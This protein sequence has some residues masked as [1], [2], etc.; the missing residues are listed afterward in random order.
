MPIHSMAKYALFTLTALAAL[1]LTALAPTTALAALETSK[2]LGHT[3][4]SIH[5]RLKV[6]V[7]IATGNA[8]YSETDFRVKTPGLPIVFTRTWNSQGSI[9]QDLGDGWIHSYG[10]YVDSYGTYGLKVIQ[11]DGRTHFYD[12]VDSNDGDS[13]CDGDGS[14]VPE[15]VAHDGPAAYMT[16]TEDVDEYFLTFEHGQ[17]VYAFD[18]DAD[19]RLW[20]IDHPNGNHITITFDSSTSD[21]DKI[22]SCHTNTI[23]TYVYAEVDVT[24][25][26]GNITAIDDG[27]GNT[28][29][30]TYSS[31]TL[32]QRAL[33]S[34]LG[35]R[36]YYYGDQE[37]I[38]STTVDLDDGNDTTNLTWV[39][40]ERGKIDA[41][42]SY[43]TDDKLDFAGAGV[44]SNEILLYHE[45]DYATPS[46]GYTTVLGPDLGAVQRSTVMT[47]TDN[48]GIA[49][50]TAS[51][52]TGCASCGGVGYWASRTYDTN[53]NPT[54][55]TSQE[56]IVTSWTWNSDGLVTELVEDDGGTAERST[57]YTY[58]ATWNKVATKVVPSVYSTN[59]KT[60][61]YTW[62]GTYGD[63]T[64]VEESGFDYE[65]SAISR[66]TTYTRDLKRR[67]VDVNGPLTGVTDK[68]FYAYWGSGLGDKSFRLRQITRRVKDVPLTN[69]ATHFYDDYDGNGDLLE[70]RDA[71][72]VKTK[73]VYDD[74]GRRT[75]THL[76]VGTEAACS[77]PGDDIC[78]QYD[79]LAN[80][81]LD[82][83]QLPKGNFV[84][85]TYDDGNR[86]TRT[87]RRNTEGGADIDYVE[88]TY[89]RENNRTATQ[90]Y[91]GADAETF[92]EEYDY[93]VYHRRTTITMADA[94]GGETP[95][96]IDF[97]WDDD[98]GL[99]S[100][101]DARSNVTAYTYDGLGR[102][103]V[104]NLPGIT[105]HYEYTYESVG[106]LTQIEDPNDHDNDYAYD[107]FG[108]VRTITTPD[109][110]TYT[111]TY[112]LAGH[113]TQRTHG[114]RPTVSYTYDNMGRLTKIDYPATFTDIT[115]TYDVSDWAPG[116]FGKGRL[117][118]MT[119]DAG[120]T[121]FRYRHDGR[122]IAEKF[123][124]GA[125]TFLTT[126][127]Y[128]LNGNLDKI[129][130]PSARDIDYK[131]QA[132]DDDR[133]DEIEGDFVAS[134]TYDFAT[135][136]T[137]L[138]GGIL[139]DFEYGNTLEFSATWSKRNQPL[140]WDV[141]TS[142]DPDSL[143]DRAYTYDDDGNITEIAFP[144][145]ETYDYTYDDISRLTEGE[146]S[147]GSGWGYRGFA[148]DDAGNVTYK[149]HDSGHTEG[150]RTTYSYVA[151]TNQ[152][153]GL[154]GYEDNDFEYNEA[155]SMDLQGPSGDD[156]EY[157]YDPD[158]RLI[159]IDD[160]NDAG[161][162]AYEYDAFNRRRVK[163]L[164]NDDFSVFFYDT[165]GRLIEEV[166]YDDSEEDYFIEDHVWMAG[167]LLARV[168]ATASS[169]G[170]A[171]TDSEVYWYH[172]DHLGTPLKMTDDGDTVV[173]AAD[174]T[175]YG[176]ATIGTETIVNNV[177]F[178]GQYWDE[179]TH[180]SDAR[181]LAQNW[182]RSYLANTGKYQGV[183]PMVSRAYVGKL[184]L[185]Y[186]YSALNPVGKVDFSGLME[187]ESSP[188]FVCPDELLGGKIADYLK[189]A[190]TLLGVGFQLYSDWEPG[191]DAEGEPGPNDIN[192]GW[193]A[194]SST[195]REGDFCTYTY[196]PANSDMFDTVDVTCSE[197]LMG[198]WAIYNA[199][200]SV[201]SEMNQDCR[202][203]LAACC[204]G[205]CPGNEIPAN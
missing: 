109:S 78:H 140:T 182:H 8:A 28:Y 63:L 158:E 90:R 73:Y 191:D 186:V 58:N 188:T 86:R 49:A 97:V 105:D 117:C 16:L 77:T 70:E 181:R 12:C 82:K 5:P 42:F 30:F 102:T 95:A 113:V 175:P 7:N 130:Y 138:P 197:G 10:W 141:G 69:L 9:D 192:S 23:D 128:D 67:V 187:R 112:D 48:D 68:T 156:Y 65:G 92:V 204:S 149:Y 159:A 193:D 199:C 125:T 179:E 196:T 127:W 198:D 99:T 154:S 56:G 120:T 98:G 75:E 21:I 52:N 167:R 183:D 203:A 66:T 32:T 170:G 80:G 15:Y 200:D 195:Q 123:L 40:D 124:Y 34:S 108:N 88:T 174:Y 116:G 94:N 59:D 60:T 137:Y 153:S 133:L 106:H 162:V 166:R 157:T 134:S 165:A 103:T 169:L 19:N 114:T 83:H 104:L 20:L 79:Y 61:T 189:A 145:S 2:N 38:N 150:N 101:T 143:I 3:P 100:R 147:R 111:F 6:P 107:D 119:D 176:E 205:A 184:S 36:Y 26:S 96:D 190:S 173:W 31:G 85:N 139:D 55:S 14:E 131:F 72:L 135:A 87:E 51:S 35:T 81:L 155:G 161:V 24:V 37:N 17:V 33:P 126:Y 132:S 172:L 201:P 146:D 164:A 13:A 62:N 136:I 84:V 43:D 50:V 53:L 142:G 47:W 46:T 151:D 74:A 18:K 160:E 202:N 76:I 152:L 27:E 93:D 168:D 129:Q 4:S 115:F 121:H 148:Y 44:V 54:A 177:R 39:K 41:V 110:G 118:T 25:T 178:P 185:A 45:F 91:T 71:N 11:G 122:T 163:L 89:D 29:T 1:A 180:S 22:Q 57:T 171:V 194:N 64:S 144:S